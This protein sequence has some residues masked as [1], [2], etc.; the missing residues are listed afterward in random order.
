MTRTMIHVSWHITTAAFATVACGLI[1]AGTVL[2]GDAARA[3]ALLA[4][5]AATAFA[6]LALVL[7]GA[8]L[9]PRAFFSHPAPIALSAIALLAW[10]G[11]L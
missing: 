4:A 11:A 7:G 2:D 8:A 5:G 10:W 6:G 3:V 1:L 9:R